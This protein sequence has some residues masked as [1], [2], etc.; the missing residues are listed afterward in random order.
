MNMRISVAT[1]ASTAAVP[2]LHIS[3][4]AWSAMTVR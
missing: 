4:W 3:A 2:S 1:N